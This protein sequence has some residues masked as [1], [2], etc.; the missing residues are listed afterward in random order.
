MTGQL[1][2]EVPCHNF[3]SK[4]EIYHVWLNQGHIVAVGSP[5]LGKNLL[6]F[7]TQHG[8]L[9]ERIISK[10]S[11]LLPNDVP[12]GIYLQK[13]GWLRPQ[14]VQLLFYSQVKQQIN[15][16]A[17]YHHGKF[18]FDSNSVLPM[19]EMTGFSIPAGKVAWNSLQSHGWQTATPLAAP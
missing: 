8:W 17:R 7:I 12:A 11:H 16:L 1:S 9:S 13:Q 19:E 3:P 4:T 10:L 2:L 6:S 15:V 5:S 18:R 14:E